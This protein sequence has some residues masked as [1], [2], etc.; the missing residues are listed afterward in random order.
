MA[1]IGC[2]G[3]ARAISDALHR[4]PVAERSSDPVD[5]EI[6]DVPR[7]ARTVS[8]TPMRVSGCV[9]TTARSA[10]IGRP[11]AGSG[12]GQSEPSTSR[13]GTTRPVG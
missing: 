6:V 12:G 1:G 4:H 9:F 2:H 10:K 13:I 7:L 11:V 3:N 5:H 8:S